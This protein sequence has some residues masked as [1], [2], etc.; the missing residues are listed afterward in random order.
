MKEK[1]REK[2]VDNPSQNGNRKTGRVEVA[3]TYKLYIGGQFPRTESGRYLAISV[4]QNTTV[5]VCRASRKDFRNAVVA[6]RSACKV[7]RSR[8]A[9]NRSQILYRM[10][11]MVETRKL[12]FIG[13][14]QLQGMSDKAA[15]ADVE[16][17]IDCIIHY[18]GWC[19]K[20]VQLFSTV[21]PVASSH[22]NFS[23][24]EPMGVV[25]VLMDETAGLQA[26]VSAIL[27]VLA[28]ANTTVTLVHISQVVVALDF[29]EV[30]QTSDLPA[31]VVNILTGKLEELLPHFSSHLD[32][33]ALIYLGD[34]QAQSMEMEKMGSEHILRVI[35]RDAAAAV[36][37]PYPIMETQEIKTTWHPIG[38]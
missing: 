28:G 31:G 26:L 21:N 1:T 4:G 17:A 35:R 37:G 7:W 12:Q 27:P 10:A 20:Y 5:N 11:E 23:V 29:A 25:G 2:K 8:S 38:K 13:D 14:L 22:F 32:V 24:P 18:A 30:L 3:K 15:H 6:A 9:Y 34:N 33:N 36:E 19:D 16:A